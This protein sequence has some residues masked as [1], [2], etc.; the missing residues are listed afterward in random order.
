MNREQAKNLLQ[1]ALANSAAEFRDGQWEALMLW[2]T[3]DK[4][5]W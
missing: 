5:C 1:T 2:S 3:N 4:S